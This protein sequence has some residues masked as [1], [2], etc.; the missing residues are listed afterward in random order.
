[1]LEGVIEVCVIGGVIEVMYHSSHVEIAC[2]YN[3]SSRN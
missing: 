3:I 2:P 1:M